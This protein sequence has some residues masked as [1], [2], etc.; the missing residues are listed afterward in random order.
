MPSPKSQS[1]ETMVPSESDEADPSKSTAV[2]ASPVYGPPG[3]AV[4]GTGPAWALMERT[5]KRDRNR[6]GNRFF[7]PPRYSFLTY[8]HAV[9]S[10]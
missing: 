1:H 6:G 9:A 10:V 5:V 3:S 8:A 4:G 7:I 2:P